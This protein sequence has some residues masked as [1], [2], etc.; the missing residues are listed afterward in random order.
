MT[1]RRYIQILVLML[2]LNLI[3]YSIYYIGDLLLSYFK[4]DLHIRAFKISM[5]DVLYVMRIRS[6]FQLTIWYIIAL[7]ISFNIKPFTSIRLAW[8]N[9][10]LYFGMAFILIS[11]MP[12]TVKILSLPLFYVFALATFMSPLILSRLPFL[13]GLMDWKFDVKE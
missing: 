12:F 1:M 13:N 11:I 3:E 8:F 4:Y 10:A 6:P 5:H 2:V 7:I 9:L